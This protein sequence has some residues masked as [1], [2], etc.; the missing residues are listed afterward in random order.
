MDIDY[1]AQLVCRIKHIVI[2]MSQNGTHSF[3]KI[4]TPKLV[5]VDTGQFD[6]VV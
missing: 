1:I 4:L 2:F 6:Y 3:I 5:Q